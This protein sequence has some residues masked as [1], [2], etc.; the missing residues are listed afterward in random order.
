[1][2]YNLP[3]EKL[4]RIGQGFLKMANILNNLLFI[5]IWQYNA[6]LILE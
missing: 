5:A 1:M 3:S 6:E 4:K 2:K